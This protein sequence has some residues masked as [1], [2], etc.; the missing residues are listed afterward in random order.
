MRGNKANQQIFLSFNPIS[1]SHWLYDFCEVNSPSSFIYHQSTFR[2]NKFLPKDYVMSLEDLYRT[3]PVKARV[4]CDGMWGVDTDGLVFP[5]HKVEDFDIMELIRETNFPIKCGVDIGF[6]DP[7]T[8]VVS[9][10]DK[11][12]K[13]IYVIAE[14]YK[15]GAS[16]EEICQGIRDCG[17]ERQKVYVDNADPRAIQYFQQE[18]INALPCKKGKDSNRL[19]ITFLQNHQII[20]H[21]SCVNVAKELE[22]FV[23]L[24]DKDGYYDENKTD[25]TFSH[26]LDGLKYSYSDVYRSK[27]LG[28]IELKLGL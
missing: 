28:S 2:D 14:Y 6:T 8:C 23:F 4:F 17:I 27:K 3:N 26:A 11:D 24:K 19:Y 10:W 16:F 1:A 15:R 22:N 25:H 18:G 7:S 13:K 5:N 20:C 21:E 9:L 12:N